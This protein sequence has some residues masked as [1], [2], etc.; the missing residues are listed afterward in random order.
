MSGVA[1]KLEPQRMSLWRRFDASGVPLLVARL[2]LGF[3]FIKMGWHKVQHP[4]EFLKLLRM[5]AILPENPPYFLNATTVLLPWLE[6]FCG[7]ALILGVFIRGA[8]LQMLIM[9]SVFTP[10]VFLRAWEIRAQTGVSFFTVAFDCGCGSGVVVI[11]KKLLENAGLWLLALYALISGSRRFTATLLFE[12][13]KPDP[14]YCHLCG[15]RVRHARA[16]LCDRCASPPEFSD[17]SAEPA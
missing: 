1:I 12:R 9:L 3:L 16:G 8:A 7:A 17:T 4:Y 14:D 5:Y 15:Y 10:V 6:I 2:V 11:W 13:R